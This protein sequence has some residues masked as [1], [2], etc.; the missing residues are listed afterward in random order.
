MPGVKG[1]LAR[2][3]KLRFYSSALT[4]RGIPTAEEAGLD[5]VQSRFKSESRYADVREQHPKDALPG[6]P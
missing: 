2:A 3:R 6:H 5:P 1:D 4:W